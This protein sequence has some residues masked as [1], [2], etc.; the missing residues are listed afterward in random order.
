VHQARFATEGFALVPGVLVPEQCSVLAHRTTGASAGGAG[1]RCLLS[2][3][4]CAALASLLRAHSTLAPLL[5][6]SPVAVQC[7]YFEKSA[8][9]NWLVPIH[10]DLS[11]PVAQRV[12]HSELRGW[13]LKE[14]ALFVQAPP[15]LL[16]RMVAV[17]VHLDDC[18]LADGPLRVVP[19]SH[20]NGVVPA[21]AA[22][23]ARAREVACVA[24]FGT[25]LIMRPLLL[26]SSSKAR[27]SSL[28]RVLHFLF[29]PREVPYGLSWQSA[30]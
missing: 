1:S 18:N 3:P 19:A 4:W 10:Q 8:S 11:V 30:A 6:E 24:H 12:V 15:P 20:L 23:Q 2:Q 5:S 16:E 14:G 21:Q 7:T 13:S 26:H 17:R 27:G 25:A 9:V 29:G 22:A 28:R